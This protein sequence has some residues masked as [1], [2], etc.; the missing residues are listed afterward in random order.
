MRCA[1]SAAATADGHLDQRER[2]LMDAELGRLKAA[3]EAQAT[4][5]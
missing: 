5:A 4:A 3:P 1:M 2:T